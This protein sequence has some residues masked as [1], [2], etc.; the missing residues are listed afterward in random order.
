MQRPPQDKA[1]WADIAQEKFLLIV[2]PE[3]ILIDLTELILKEC[4]TF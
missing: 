3:F 2:Q 1:V 4:L